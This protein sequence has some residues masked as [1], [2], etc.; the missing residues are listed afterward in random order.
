[1]FPG[2][3][4]MLVAPYQEM[5]HAVTVTAWGWVDDLDAPD[6]DRLLAFYKA[7]VDKGPEQAL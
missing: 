2:T 4:K 5:D 6:K 3:R 7:H 1:M